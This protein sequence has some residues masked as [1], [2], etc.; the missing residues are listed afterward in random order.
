MRQDGK[1]LSPLHM[2]VVSVVCQDKVGPVFEHQKE[3]GGDPETVLEQINREKFNEFFE[4]Y[5]R[6]KAEN[7][8]EWRTVPSHYSV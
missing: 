8:L 2:E 6:T 3:A 4:A 1:D 7:S 5:R